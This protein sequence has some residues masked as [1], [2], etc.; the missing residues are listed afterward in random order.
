MSFRIEDAISDIAVQLSRLGVPFALVGGIAV[1][2]RAEVR[3]TRD[4]DVAVS[5]PDD[6]R[7]EWLVRELRAAGYAP[8]T[9]VEQEDMQRIATVRLRSPSG[10]VVDLLSATCGIEHE[11][12]ARAS[13]VRFEGVGEY[14]VARAEELLAMKLLSM[15][16]Q[17]LQDR[18]DA[19]NLIS[20]LDAPALEVVADT[21]RTVTT[22]GYH[23]GQNLAAK[24]EATLAAHANRGAAGA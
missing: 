24:L 16:E 1:S 21:L 20:V 8:V 13:S 5:V 7:T 4:V 2:I 18:I 17:R 3:F 9:L 11:V 10:F 23:R 19:L 22:R 6:A 12:V 15:S 14:P